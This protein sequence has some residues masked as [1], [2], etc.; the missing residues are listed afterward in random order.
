MKVKL[1]VFSDVHG[2]Y[3]ALQASLR[4]AGYNPND[5]TH[6]LLSIGDNFD[7]GKQSLQLYKMLRNRNV[8]CV[9]GNHETFLEEALEKGMDGEFVLFNFLRN[10]LDKT[11]QSFSRFDFPSIVDPKTIDNAICEI[12]NNFPDMLNWLKNMPLFYET[13]NYIFVHAGL[14]PYKPFEAAKADPDFC[15]WDIEFSHLPIDYVPKTVVIGHHHAFRVRQHALEAG[16]CEEP[17]R[18]PCYGNTDEHRPVR[19]GNKIAIDPCSNYT[20]KVNVLV[21]E[22][23]LLEE[24]KEETQKTDPNTFT[25]LSFDEFD[26][27]IATWQYGTINNATVRFR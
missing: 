26:P 14:H 12:N 23:E 13:K 11:I 16:Y 19:I 27:G 1:F 5:K 3:E 24:V 2:Q 7:R 8:I 21:I 20:G 17:L 18:L 22:D 6:R 10:G 15:L 4:E 9:K 25:T